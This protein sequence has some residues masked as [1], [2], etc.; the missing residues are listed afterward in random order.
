MIHFLIWSINFRQRKIYE[1]QDEEGREAGGSGIW[2]T[3]T[4]RTPYVVRTKYRYEYIIGRR[5]RLP[6]A[7]TTSTQQNWGQNSAL[8][9]A[10]CGH[11][12][13]DE[14]REK[15]KA[16]GDD[17][18]EATSISTLAITISVERELVV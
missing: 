13:R 1:D 10:D 12:H 6:I 7:P 11:P 17:D 5:R 14:R 15:T 18:D 3:R 9:I 4:A 16:G 2:D 8:R